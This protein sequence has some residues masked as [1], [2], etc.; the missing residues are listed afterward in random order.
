MRERLLHVIGIGALGGRRVVGRLRGASPGRTA[1][2]ITGVAVAVGLLMVV[3]GLSLGLATGATVDGD[4]VNYWIVPDDGNAGSVPLSAEGTQLGDVHTTAARI[5]SDERVRYATPV[6]IHPIRIQNP[7]TDERMYV[8]ALGIIPTAEQTHISGLNIST[9]DTAY[10]HYANGTYEGAW[11]GETVITPA[12]SA[13][14]GTERGGPLELARDDREL[15]V[16]GAAET[17]L[18]AGVGEVPAVVMPLAELQTVTGT[19]SGDQADQIMVSTSDSRVRESLTGIYPR[20]KVITRSGI[21]GADTTPTSLPL[22]MA[23]TASLVAGGIGVAF[24]A[25]M[26]GLELTAGRRELAMLGAIGF[27]QRSRALLS[28]SETLIV[29]ALG[30]LLGVVFGTAGILALNAGIAQT[31]GLSTVAELSLPLAGYAFVMALLVGLL[32][33]PYPLY[34]ALR[35]DT[36]EE[37]T[38]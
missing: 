33:A 8:L 27:S 13:E 9:L 6:A 29:S 23:L 30:G 16:V 10:P 32:S 5:E 3:T 17:N 14:I 28:V 38:R 26:M 12:V 11:T 1:V 20:T 22:A 37:L 4:G 2:C 24:V 18:S 7:E 36:L 21:V 15:D 35:T 31:I 34:L 25:T 19:A